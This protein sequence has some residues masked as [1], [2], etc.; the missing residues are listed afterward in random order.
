MGA[1]PA[2]DLNGLVVRVD[3]R[4]FH[5]Q[6]LYGWAKGWANEVWLAHDTV[7]KNPDERSLYEEQMAGVQGGILSIDEAVDRYK[8]CGCQADKCL[9]IVGSCSD[10]KRLINGGAVPGEIHLA[11]LGQGE[12]KTQIAESVSLSDDDCE[13][14]RDLQDDGFSICLRK[15]PQSKTKDVVIP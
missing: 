5:G 2:E 4:L 6:I 10:L 12:N 13:I 3:D 15:L 1:Q 11:N 8:G 14:I 7:A 9:L